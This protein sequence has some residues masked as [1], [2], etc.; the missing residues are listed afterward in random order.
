MWVGARAIFDEVPEDTLLIITDEEDLADFVDFG[1][2]GEAVRD[3][4]MTG[5]F[6]KWLV[7]ESEQRISG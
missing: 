2:S 7:I 4:W 3:D 6:E 1:D 5:D